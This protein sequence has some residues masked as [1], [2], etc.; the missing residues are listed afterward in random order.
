MEKEELIKAAKI[1]SE[2]KIAAEGL[3]AKALK[4][5]RIYAGEKSSFYV[6]LQQSLC[7]RRNSNDME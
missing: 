4:F 2:S 3:L 5:L 1:I 7:R 6:R